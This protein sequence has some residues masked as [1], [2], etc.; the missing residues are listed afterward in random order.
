MLVATSR[1][2][3]ILCCCVLCEQ[4]SD[5][6]ASVNGQA[7]KLPA[8]PVTEGISSQIT[9]Q[10]QAVE[11]ADVMIGTAAESVSVSLEMSVDQVSSQDKD[12]Q[13]AQTLANDDPQTSKITAKQRKPEDE[14]FQA[15]IETHTHGH[16]V[17]LSDASV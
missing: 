7:L 4:L 3:R 9:V 15:Q 11:G 5:E 8:M 6:A 16:L 12:E 10:T 14:T 1:W 17:S 13:E 2:R